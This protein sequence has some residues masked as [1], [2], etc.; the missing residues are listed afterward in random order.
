L[1]KEVERTYEELRSRR[2][3]TEEAVKRILDFS[4]RIVKW[5]REEKEIGKEKYPLYEALKNVLPEIEKQRAI[6]FINDLLTHLEKQKLLFKGW[7]LQRDVRRKVKA[8]IRL[9]LLSK[10]RDYGSKM[11]ELTDST[12]EALEGIR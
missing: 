2:I 9:L 1:S 8:E 7:Q 4:E 12:F 10:F 6:N 11:D 3:E 5:K